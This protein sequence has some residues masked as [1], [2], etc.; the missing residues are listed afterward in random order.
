MCDVTVVCR[1]DECRPLSAH[2]HAWHIV[3]GVNLPVNKAGM[4]ESLAPGSRNKRW[5][6]LLVVM[7]KLL[8]WRL[9]FTL[10]VVDWSCMTGAVSIVSNE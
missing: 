6:T 8:L 3:C 1:C 5:V 9:H 2:G 10:L 7:F 4:V